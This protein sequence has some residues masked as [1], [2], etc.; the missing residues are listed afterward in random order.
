VPTFRDHIHVAKNLLRLLSGKRPSQTGM[1][2][3]SR[4][5]SLAAGM[6]LG[7][8]LQTSPSV[9]APQGGNPDQFQSLTPRTGGDFEA[10]YVPASG[11]LVD[12]FVVRS[13]LENGTVTQ[14]P[15][16][17][18][19]F[20]DMLP[21][22]D[23]P[24]AAPLIYIAGEMDLN[25]VWP[26]SY[27]FAN[28][29]AAALPGSQLDDK[30][31]NSWLRLYTLRGT[32]HAPREA[33]FA[34]PSN[35]GDT[36]WYEYLGAGFN[37]QRRGLEL[38]AW[39]DALRAN[40]PDLLGDVPFGID[41]M[42]LH[43]ASAVSE[44]GFSLQAI[45]NAGRWAKTGEAPPVSALPAHLVVNPTTETPAVVYPIAEAC[46]PDVVFG[47]LATCLQSLTADSIMNDPGQGY[48]PLGDPFLVD[49]LRTFAGGPLR[50]TTEPVD[51]PGQAV[52]LG[53]RLFTPGPVFLR[54]FTKAELRLR[55]KN[56][57]GY[58]ARVAKAVARLVSRGLYDPRIG[59]GDIAAASRSSVLK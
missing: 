28:V 40:N 49:I 22:P 8:T 32:T 11:K 47:D 24:I 19:E 31:I 6:N 18:P 48:G 37:N 54:P 57:A 35:G 14:P 23:Y 29:L 30:D 44:E 1:L 12:W 53:Y 45:V 3:W 10:P 58:V 36:T 15:D 9:I 38:P 7:R 34:G 13:G 42:G 20:T 56:H 4:S 21:D 52:P 5:G 46:T 16:G 39:S 51:L 26:N 55:Y 43:N 25:Y 33:W 2:A 59:A 27:Y 41:F 17:H 50:F